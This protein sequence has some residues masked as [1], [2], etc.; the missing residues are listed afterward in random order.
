MINTLA[1]Y[2]TNKD[3]AKDYLLEIKQKWPRYTRDHLQVIQKAIT[4]TD[5]NIADKT[6][7]F[8]C[9][10]EIMHGYEFEQALFVLLDEKPNNTMPAEQIKLLG[11]NNQ[12][13]LNQLPQTSNI[14]DYE[15]IINPVCRQGRK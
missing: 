12:E 15:K 9:K 8:C 7:D 3:L 2:F 11:K 6:L 5:K 13:G 4:Y 14:E 1:G 10:N